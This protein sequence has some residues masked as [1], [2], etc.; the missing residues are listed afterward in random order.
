MHVKYSYEHKHINFLCNSLVNFNYLYFK[1]YHNLDFF[2]LE[3]FY[4]ILFPKYAINKI[5][6]GG[7]ETF[8]YSIIIIKTNS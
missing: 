1:N 5:L 4:F 2:V 6:Y 7:C 8:T 3:N